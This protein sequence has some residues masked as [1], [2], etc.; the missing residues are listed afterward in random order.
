MTQLKSI[1][2]FPNQATSFVG[3]EE[4]LAKLAA[5]LAEPSS[6]LINLVGPGGIG[7]TRLA[8]Q[9]AYE[10][11]QVFTGVFFVP[12]QAVNSVDALTTAIVDSIGLSLQGN[13]TPAA[14]LLRYLRDKRLLLIV[15]NLDHLLAGIDV[16]LEILVDAP[17][18]KILATSREVLNVRQERVWP[19]RGMLF[20]DDP[21]VAAA[22][23]FGAV[24]LFVECA[25]RVR[26]DFSL[27]DDQSSVIRICQIVEGVPLAIELAASWLRSLPASAIVTEIERNLDFLDTK[28]R[29]LPA[30]HRSIRAVFNESWTQLSPE[31]RS[32]FIQLAIFRGGFRREVA[33]Q[34]VG[35]SLPLLSTLIDKSLIR[36]EGNGR[37][38]MHELLRQF[39]QEKLDEQGDLKTVLLDKHCAFY[40]TYLQEHQLSLANNTSGEIQ[41]L[42]KEDADNISSAWDYALEQ[43]DE[44]VIDQFLIPLFYLYFPQNHFYEG[45]RIFRRAL[46]C[47]QGFTEDTLSL[48]QA[49]AYLCLAICLQNLTRYDEAYN[50]LQKCIPTL[51]VHQATWE[52]WNA[53]ACL[54]NIAYSKG[55]YVRAQQHSENVREMLKGGD[56]PAAL[57]HTLAR[58]SDLAGVR[59]DYLTA[60][61]LLA[62]AITPLES[63]GNS[64]SRVRFLMTLG[65]IEYKLGN[66]EKAEAHFE[67]ART[68]SKTLDDSITYAIS[69]V[70]LG[71]VAYAREDFTRATTLHR[72]GIKLFDDIRHL[73]GKAFALVHLGRAYVELEQFDEAYQQFSDATLI[74]ESTGSQWLNAVCY[75]N[76]GRLHLLLGRQESAFSD[77]HR[78]LEIAHDIQTVP[79]MLDIFVVIA[80]AAAIYRYESW[81]VALASY[82]AQ[83]SLSEFAT[84]TQATALLKHLND[85]PGAI[86]EF[87]VASLAKTTLSALLEGFETVQPPFSIVR[88]RMLSVEGLLDPLT[89]R[90]LEILRL[91][92]EG[93]SNQE[94]AERL[95]L[96]IGTVKAHNHNIFSKLGVKNRVQA[97]TQARELGLI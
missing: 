37:Y 22:E 61:Q 55:D 85:E 72:E 76:Q 97:I 21:H 84:H 60:K 1:S 33:E 40:A 34:V 6:R 96:V 14:Q 11:A 26:P 35:A 41:T 95:F 86:P 90:E 43:C 87:P 62:E 77:L 51:E 73:W 82:V 58:L 78:A 94:I 18:V 10:S 71:R 66:Y 67:S 93:H 32:L 74:A 88:E 12:L 53:Q 70:S 29:D 15:D 42:M 23:D 49:R 81:A 9:A 59:G 46:T 27:K 52:M 17:Q 68:L 19:V 5:M 20:P 83:N 8:L 80:E 79:L 48:P 63:S 57:A 25:R 65:D 16:L 56:Q 47:L 28:L 2:S 4:D 89:E 31:E 7:K 39:A 54:A 36:T 44:S 38:H 3:R 91:L 50:L 30:R 75:Y 64:R 69:L 13:E 92:S 45:A 24:R